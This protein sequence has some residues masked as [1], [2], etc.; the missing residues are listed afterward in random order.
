MKNQAKNLKCIVILIFVML[1]SNSCTK[2]EVSESF[3]KTKINGKVI[4]EVTNQPVSGITLYLE[5]VKIYGSG[6]GS[7]KETIDVRNVTTDQNGNF[8]VSLRNSTNTYLVIRKEFDNIYGAY[9]GGQNFAAD[10]NYS[11]IDLTIKLQK[12]INFKINVK[13]TAP[14]NNEDYIDV[15]FAYHRGQAIRKEILNFGIPNIVYPAQGGF[16]PRIETAWQG[17]NVNSTIFYSVTEDSQYYKIYWQKRKNG[18]STQGVTNDIPY[19]INILN[20]YSFNY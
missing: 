1:F 7:Y 19:D 2:S 3:Y 5:I 16:G 17:I 9:S 10:Q 8:E 20:E 13:N 14:S 12:F 18:I 15:S 11:N 6:Y 4:R